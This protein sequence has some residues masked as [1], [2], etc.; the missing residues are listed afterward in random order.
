MGGRLTLYL[1]STGMVEAVV[2]FNFGYFTRSLAKPLDDTEQML[3]VDVVQKM[4]GDNKQKP[5]K[6]GF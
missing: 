4:L 3:E 2:G 5:G 6:L 1:P